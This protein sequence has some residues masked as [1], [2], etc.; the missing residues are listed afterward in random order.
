[1]S[2][3]ETRAQLQRGLRIATLILAV[4]TVDVLGL[5][6]LLQGL[7]SHDLP[8]AQF[9]AFAALTAVLATEAVLVVR[10]RSWRTGRRIAIAVV[11]AAS[12]LSY[13][14]LPDGMTSTTVDWLFGAANWAGAVVLLDRPFRIFLAFLVTHELLA[15][16]NL[17]V[18]HEVNR[19]ALVRFTTG[20]VTVFGLPL[21]MAVVAAVLGGIATEAA[22]SARELELARTAE[23][24]ASA[25]HRRRTQ[26]FAELSGTTVP[27][28][29]GL[30]DGSLEP[31]DPAVQRSCAIEA[32]RMRR[33]F[34]ETDTV[35][36]PLLHELRH[37]AEIADRKGVEVELDARGQWPTPP[38]AVR[39][40]LTDAALTALATAGS[41]AR[42]TVVGSTDAVSVSV[43]ADCAEHT[44]PSPA[45]PDVRIE[46][47][48]SGG[49]MWMEAQW[50]P[51]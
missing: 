3:D 24:A 28:L 21:L 46:I 51:S 10:R 8:A 16:A 34:A 15:L 4:L 5:I 36:N 13:L 11:L 12:A 22:R 26:R 18:F 38:V 33:L 35:D 43:V 29:T 19:A 44:V 7:E 50:Q 45:T 49:T 32:S 41:W 48:G 27:L 2:D 40:D 25:A 17:L 47:F 37:C 1:M 39:R 9:A 30:A 42:V 23:A 6:H 31:S 20:S 14:T